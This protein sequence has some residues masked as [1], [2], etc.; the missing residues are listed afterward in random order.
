V[1]WGA[2]LIHHQA[3]EVTEPT[4][5]IVSE[6]CAEIK[7]PSALTIEVDI[8]GE[9]INAIRV[10]GRVVAVAEGKVWL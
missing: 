6:Q 7:R 2:Y 1:H 5:Y 8:A 3:V 10:G 9:T 4:T